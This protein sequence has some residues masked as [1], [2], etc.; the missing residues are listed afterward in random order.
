MPQLILAPV[1]R[2]THQPACV[3][4]S[5]DPPPP[6]RLHPNLAKAYRNKVGQLH[7]A[8]ADPAIRDEAFEILRGLINRVVVHPGDD[9][10][11]DRACGR[12]SYR[13][14]CAAGRQT[15][16]AVKGAACSVKFEI[17]TPV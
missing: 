14:S 4:R 11:P 1:R 10:A 17:S 3:A 6:V 2:G 15:G 9:G 16:R 5:A 13:W 12:E 7:V 8:L